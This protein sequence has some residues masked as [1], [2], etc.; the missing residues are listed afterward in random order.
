LSTNGTGYNEYIYGPNGVLDEGEDFIDYGWD[1]TK[2][3]AGK[4]GTLQKDTSELPTTGSIWT[5]TTPRSTRANNITRW[6]NPNNY[7]RRA[8]RLFDGE[9]LSYTAVSGKLSP[10]K[11]ITIASENMVYL[12]GN[13]NTTGVSSIP[14]SGST[15]NDGGYLGAQIPSSIVCDALF[16][17]SKTWFDGLSALYPEG[18]SDARNK[19]GT[20][21]RMADDILPDVTESTSVRAAIISGSNPSAMNETPGRDAAGSRKSGGMNNL[22]R[23]LEQW[24]M[25]MASATPWNYTGSMIDLYFSTQAVSQAEN[26]TSVTYMPPRRNWSFDSTF[27]NANKLPPATPFFQYVQATG[28]RQNIRN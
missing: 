24:N 27:L 17:L 11:G 7:F 21:Y 4:K 6:A 20:V 10:T 26:S 12:W 28:F 13:Y 8:V 15:L 25:S 5:P 16:P 2:S 14:A 18:T 1:A 3:A 19:S 23:F 22:P 9:T